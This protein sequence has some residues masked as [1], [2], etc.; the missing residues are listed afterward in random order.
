MKQNSHNKGNTQNICN[1]KF[2]HLIK[3]FEITEKEK[4]QI[5]TCIEK[6]ICQFLYISYDFKTD[7]IFSVHNIPFYANLIVFSVKLT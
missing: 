6:R 4:M 7:T 3:C 5:K 2:I 1:L